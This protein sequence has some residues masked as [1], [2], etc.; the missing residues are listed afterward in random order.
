MLLEDVVILKEDSDRLNLVTTQQAFGNLFRLQQVELQEV[1]N[2]LDS[3]QIP[4]L[5]QLSV[6]NVHT[7]FSKFP[8]GTLCISNPSDNLRSKNFGADTSSSVACSV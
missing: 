2:Y 3:N 5:I 6:L 8:I 4:S 7:V 1:I